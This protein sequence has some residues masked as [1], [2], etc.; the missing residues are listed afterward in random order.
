M[1]LRFVGLAVRSSD[2]G[3]LLVELG[4]AASTLSRAVAG[5]VV[6]VDD[7][8]TFSVA[9]RFGWR[10]A[11]EVQV[12]DWSGA[13][14][15]IDQGLGE[16]LRALF[17]DRFRAAKVLPLTGHGAMYG[18]LVLLY[19][20]PLDEE[21]TVIRGLVE[22]TTLGLDRHVYDRR[23]AATFADLRESRD[24]QA[25]AY[26]L[27]ALGQMAAG[28]S[29]DLKNILNPLDLQIQLLRRL[30]PRDDEAITET[31]D[32]MKL[33]IR[34]GV[35]TIDR[36]RGFSR[37]TPVDSEAAVDVDHLVREA[38]EIASARL[39]S[40]VSARVVIELELGATRPARA[41]GSEVVAAVVNL[42]VNAIDATLGVDAPCV[43][44]LSTRDAAE[45]VAIEVKDDGPGMPADVA[46]RVFEPF[47]S[48]KGAK[49][50]G[51]GLSNVYA[52]ARRSGGRIELD[53][54][55]GE[56]ARFTLY[57]PASEA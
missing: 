32:D 19:E 38:R 1:L 46:K 36:L 2:P 12:D 18:A 11:D 14:E 22:L 13:L 40:P 16:R 56:G 5:V 24:A 6:Q 9:Y 52:F 51:L 35:D 17:G 3:R 48:T 54:A 41:V 57:L 4:E 53:T 45:W 30:V 25:R 42:V 37:Q 33:V 29:H 55:E 28:V 27:G 39:V 31:L 21:L 50:T 23:L 26:R 34:R 7:Q 47:F 49:G 15:S 43:V 10:D 44:T 8:A 20:E